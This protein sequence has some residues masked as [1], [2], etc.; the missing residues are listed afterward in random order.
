MPM[1]SDALK[2]VWER[3]PLVVRAVVIGFLVF[4]I[5][6]SLVWT[7]FLIF[8]PPPWPFLAMAVVLVVYVQ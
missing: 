1:K 4:A 5:A 7:A 8:L 6:G 2:T 3:I